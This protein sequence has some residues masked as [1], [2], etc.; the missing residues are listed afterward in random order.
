MSGLEF[1]EW[2]AF[3]S[4]EPFGEERGDLRMGILASLYANAHRD[5]RKAK[6]YEP[7]DFIPTFNEPAQSM[8]EQMAI[9]QM[10]AELT[11]GDPSLL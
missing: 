3:Y 1:A 2:L 10:M 4:L 6:T 7:K 11:G 8:E 9:A 5:T